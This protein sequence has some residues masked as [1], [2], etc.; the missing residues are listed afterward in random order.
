VLHPPAN[1]Y[2]RPLGPRAYLAL[3]AVALLLAGAV[4]AALTA[5]RWM[6]DR[7]AFKLALA[8]FIAP[9]QELYLASLPGADGTEYVIFLRAGTA[10]AEVSRVLAAEGLQRVERE[11]IFPGT[12]V[13]RAAPGQSDAARRLR[14]QPFVK[15]MV[16]NGGVYFCH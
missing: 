9:Y 5:E 2:A 11:G 8:T 1:P 13:V 14:E 4:G 7:K 16:R 6:G 12:V 15:L 10:D 3:A